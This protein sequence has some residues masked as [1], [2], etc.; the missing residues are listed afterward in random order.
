VPC[1]TCPLIRLGTDLGA[2][3]GRQGQESQHPLVALILGF[4]SSYVVRQS[5][6]VISVRDMRGCGGSKIRAALPFKIRAAI[7]GMLVQE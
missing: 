7:M 3:Q 6:A 4:V 1:G 5:F 2:F